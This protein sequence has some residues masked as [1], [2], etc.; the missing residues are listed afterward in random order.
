[1]INTNK[2]AHILMLNNGMPPRV[3]GNRLSSLYN[4]NA[5]QILNLYYAS[6]ITSKQELGVNTRLRVVLI[7]QGSLFGRTGPPTERHLKHSL[8]ESATRIL[9]STCDSLRLVLKPAL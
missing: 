5:M 1:M 9:S 4:K 3:E 2:C 7:L 6:S 8:G